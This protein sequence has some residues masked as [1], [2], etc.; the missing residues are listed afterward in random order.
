MGSYCI[1]QNPW[2]KIF[3][4]KCVHSQVANFIIENTKGVTLGMGSAMAHTDPFTG[5]LIGWL[6]S[7]LTCWKTNAAGDK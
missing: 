2:L 3:L 6:S 5:L 4:T 1:F 7:I